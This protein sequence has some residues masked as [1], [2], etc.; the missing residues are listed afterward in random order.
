MT[1]K[2]AEIEEDKEGTR[3]IMTIGTN[4]IFNIIRAD[5]Y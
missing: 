3:V 4:N 2:A 5:E 1:N